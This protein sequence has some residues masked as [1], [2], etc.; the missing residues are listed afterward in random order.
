MSL[1][2]FKYTVAGKPVRMP[3]YDHLDK[4][5]FRYKRT[6]VPILPVSGNIA[7]NTA[8]VPLWEDVA[9]LGAQFHQIGVVHR[10]ADLPSWK[11]YPLFDGETPNVRRMSVHYSVLLPGTHHIRRTHIARKKFSS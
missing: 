8:A 5:P 9:A 1:C 3:D 4:W 2:F 6:R 7:L 10:T 11:P